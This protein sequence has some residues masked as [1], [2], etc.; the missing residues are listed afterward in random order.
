MA[1]S[2]IEE[3][4]IIL[5]RLKPSEALWLLEAMQN[6]LNGMNPLSESFI[7]SSNRETIHAAL[8]QQRKYLS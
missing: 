4:P 5:L 8:Q 7:D 6:P 3:N 2:D 1:Q